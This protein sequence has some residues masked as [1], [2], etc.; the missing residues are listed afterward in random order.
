MEER[1]GLRESELIGRLHWYINIR[2]VTAAF[3]AAAAV[4][5]RTFFN[6][7]LPLQT[8]L[9]IALAV[10]LYNFVFSLHLGRIKTSHAAA[11]DLPKRAERFVMLQ[12]ASDLLALLFLIHYTGGIENPFAFYFI[13]HTVL[14]SLLLKKN[15]SYL[16]ALFAVLSVGIL[17]LMEYFSFIPHHHMAGFIGAEL[18]QNPKYALAFYI[19]F[20]SVIFLVT[21]ITASISEKLRRKETELER[22]NA[23]LIEKDRLKSEYVRMVAHDIRSPLASVLSLLSVAIEGYSG[24]L[25]EKAAEVLK[26]TL[27]RVESLHAYATDLLNLSKVRSEKALEPEPMDIKEILDNALKIT[28]PEREGKD[29]DI[30][31]ELEEGLPEI[32]A[33]RE[34]VLYLLVNLIGNAVK[35]TPGHGSIR[36][37]GG[38][39]GARLVLA[40]SDTGIGIPPGDIPHIYDEFFRG[41][42]VRERGMGT[43]LGLT[44]VK[45]IVDRQNGSI[46]VESELGRGTTFTVK[47]PFKRQRETQAEP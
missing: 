33:V 34:E 6:V 46:G 16:Q 43:G 44:L 47:L 28:G 2:W 7:L 37:K 41:S 31:V 14:S 27:A 9:T 45:F 36:I 25:P 40:V 18:Y 22:A 8:I 17:T 13:F 10:A 26:R 15:A 12:A 1:A 4:A 35:Y 23:S 20:G 24:S 38:K 5:S 11:A 39:E 30:M 32:L 19:V 3:I 42:N 29:I 21:H